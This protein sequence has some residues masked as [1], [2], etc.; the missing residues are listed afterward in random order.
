[1]RGHRWK[2]FC[3]YCRF[4]GWTILAAIFTLC[5]GFL[6]LEPYIKTSMARFYDDLNAPAGS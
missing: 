5:I 1:M 6:W 2:L 3:L 4:I